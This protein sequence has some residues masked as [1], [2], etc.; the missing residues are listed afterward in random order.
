MRHVVLCDGIGAKALVTGLLYCTLDG[1]F[2]QSGTGAAKG[3]E[4]TGAH[5]A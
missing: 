1:E 2:R 5:L 4:P 3:Y